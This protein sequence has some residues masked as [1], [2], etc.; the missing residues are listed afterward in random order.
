MRG[1]ALVL[2]PLL[3]GGC[4]LVRPKDTRPPMPPAM[5]PDAPYEHRHAHYGAVHGVRVD[6]DDLGFS[7]KRG[8]YSAPY[9]LLGN[10]RKVFDADELGR[11]VGAE[12]ELGRTLAARRR[13]KARNRRTQ[14]IAG[15][16]IAAGAALFAL[17]GL[18]LANDGPVHGAVPIGLGV[19]AFFGGAGYWVFGPRAEVPDAPIDEAMRSTYNAGV[20]ETLR[21]CVDGLVIRDCQ[22][23]SGPPGAAT[24]F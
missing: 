17:G 9:L 4:F 10:G 8:R 7:L 11:Q 23:P 18:S 14:L 12:T 22:Q 13:A 15:G 20:A 21:L 16:S 3:L 24:R 19:A 5:A 6:R 2:A 1:R